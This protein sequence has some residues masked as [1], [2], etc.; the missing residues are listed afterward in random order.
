MTTS[1]GFSPHLK[2]SKTRPQLLSDPPL[3][4]LSPNKVKRLIPRVT[5]ATTTYLCAENF[6][7]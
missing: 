1:T 7:L 2:R 5:R 6:R 3:F 4:F